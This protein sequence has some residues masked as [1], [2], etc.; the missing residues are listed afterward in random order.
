MERGNEGGGGGPEQPPHK[1]IEMVDREEAEGD[2]KM[3]QVIRDIEMYKK[4]QEELE[5]EEINITKHNFEVL[6]N[7]RRGQDGRDDQVNEMENFAKDQIEIY[8]KEL[9]K[10][11]EE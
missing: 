7:V 1:I 4:I 3:S 11:Q 10:E 5:Q 9:L 6:E 2:A 8:R